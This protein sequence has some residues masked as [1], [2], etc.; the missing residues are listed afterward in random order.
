MLRNR[1]CLTLAITLLLALVWQPAMGASISKAKQRP[2][3]VPG[4]LIVKY[5][6]GVAAAQ[7]LAALKLLSAGDE[8]ELAGVPRLTMV[9][10]PATADVMQ[11]ARQLEATGTVEYAEPDYY[12]YPTA[13]IDTTDLA[14]C[15]HLDYATLA[16]NPTACIH[17][18]DPQA[19]AAI[20]GEWYLENRGIHE[21]HADTGLTAAWALLC[22]PTGGHCTTGLAPATSTD[23]IIAI[24]D[25][26]FDLAMPDL[27]GQFILSGGTDCSGGT[28][29][30]TAQATATDGT[31]DHG[32]MVAST[33]AAV[34]N[35]AEA[36]AGVTWDAKIIPIKTD[37]TSSAIIAGIKYAI[38]HHARIINE[39]FG[40]P[41]PSLAEYD[42]LVDAENADILVVVAAGNS[43]SDNDLAGAFYPANYAGQTVIFPKTDASGDPVAGNT[44]SKPGLSNIVTVGATDQTD[45]LTSWS[46]WGSFNVGL[47]AP[48]DGIIAL[49][50][51]TDDGLIDVA[52]TSFASPITAGS[53]ALVGEY[54]TVVK[55]ETPDWHDIKAQILH[56]SEPSQTT[57]SI[58]GRS[59][60]GRLNTYL[61]MQDMTH[62]VI[63]VRGATI[64]NSA[65]SNDGEINPS[66]AANLVVTVAN[67]GPNETDVQGTLSYAG[68]GALASVTAGTATQDAGAIDNT[69]ATPNIVD[70][71]ATMSFP[72]QFHAINGNQSLLFKLHVTTASGGTADRFFYLQ[73][74]QLKNGVT[75]SSNLTRTPYDDFQ[76]WHIDV[77]AG[78]KNLVVWSTTEGSVDIDLIAMK[79]RLPQY[80]ETLGVDN[81]SSDPEFQQYI[82][83]DAQT[84]GRADGD[85]SVAYDGLSNP[86]DSVVQPVTGAGTYH[87]VVVNF[88]GTSGQAYKLTACYAPAGTDQITFDGNYE[89]DE[90][91]GTAKLTL[92]RSGTS[93]AVSV[94]Y[95]TENGGLD[96]NNPSATS[97]T[98]Y[99]AAQGTVSWAN[100]D[101]AAKTFT[102]P[103]TNT[104]KI[105]TGA[106]NFLHFRVALSSLTG[107]AQGGCI[108]TADV[109]IGN[110]ATVIPSSGGTSGGGGGTPPPPAKGKSGGGVT[111]LLSLLGLGFA[112]LRR[113]Y[114]A[115]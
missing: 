94:A 22:A 86:F 44:T 98:N 64:D 81:P 15:T 112:L 33:M 108:V 17:P 101:G 37:L 62:G 53:A 97:G 9:T 35:N 92:L 56:G 20:A 30:G 61:A 54:R 90:A 18:D 96:S 65:T 10:L 4:R 84:S 8:R 67:L 49:Q 52:G 16:T 106:A 113:R 82:E 111:D 45:S 60:T 78:G 2:L 31:Q 43:D 51:G 36:I 79:N 23:F 80:L 32:T 13:L 74:G 102:I 24:I 73:A 40:G 48:G 26:G 105:A 83:P 38:A 93:G 66:E 71:I 34:G 99:T 63:V 25:N 72:V 55:S 88:T 21:L 109:A 39:S 114:A 11:A 76:D 47:L 50:R 70:G 27:Q 103:L 87:V 41:V 3:Y 69:G 91:A 57:N 14:Q 19:F 46:Q 28:C 100:G 95:A 104:G 6:P 29:K 7:H 77:P 89:Y 42:A 107:G 115:K 58:D 5:K 110:P 1:S 85:E 12:R 68:T 59:A 75:V